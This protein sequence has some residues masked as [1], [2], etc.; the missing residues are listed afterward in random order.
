MG[1][2][3]TG[4]LDQEYETLCQSYDSK[5]GARQISSADVIEKLN[6]KEQVYILDTRSEAEHLVSSLPNCHLLV[7]SL[8]ILS[9]SYTTP[10][11]EV[12]EIPK[13]A[14]IICHCTAGLRSGWAAVDLEKKWNRK[15][16]SL[17]GGI[18][19]WSNAGGHLYDAD[20]K[21]TSRV[22]CYS[23]TWGKYLKDQNNVVTE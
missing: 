20:G 17:H 10:L 3:Q 8:G 19:S 14:T 21:E 22:H 13:D 18:I 1:N 5:T 15:V 12:T 9:I 4:D 16:F 23:N 7:P 2:A 11:P 6:S